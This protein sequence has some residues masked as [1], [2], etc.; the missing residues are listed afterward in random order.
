VSADRVRRPGYRR[1]GT[2]H[3]YI[4]LVKDLIRAAYNAEDYQIEAPAW[5]ESARFDVVANVPP[6]ATRDD[7]NLMLQNLLADRFQLKLHRS[8]R[9]LPIYALVVAENDAT[10]KASVDDPNA[11][12][13]RGTISV[14]GP[15]KRFEFDG[16]TMAQ[17]AD[18]LA[19]E[20]DRPVIDMT[21]LTGK[22]DVRLEF[23][24]HSRAAAISPNPQSAVEIFTALTEQ[25]GLKLEPTKGPVALLVVDSALKQPTEN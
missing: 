22:Y 3:V 7:V 23:A 11:A 21:G 13:G 8:T 12:K 25:L 19:R 2:D 16:F 18:V 15:R 20:V 1:A 24:P 10:L 14:G 6:G 9:E 4:C 17:F 5:L